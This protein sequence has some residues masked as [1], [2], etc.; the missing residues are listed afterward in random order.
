MLHAP[1]LCFNRMPPRTT[2]KSHRPRASNRIMVATRHHVSLVA[3]QKSTAA[4]LLSLLAP[5]SQNGPRRPGSAPPRLSARPGQLRPVLTN[6]SQQEGKAG[7]ES[8]L[9]ARTNLRWSAQQCPMD[10]SGWEDTDARR[11]Q[12]SPGAECRQLGSGFQ[13]GGRNIALDIPFYR[14]TYRN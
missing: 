4:G 3:F 2:Q 11:P 9:S 10:L 13:L 12:T 7:T 8:I 5:F 14:I 1:S 6:T